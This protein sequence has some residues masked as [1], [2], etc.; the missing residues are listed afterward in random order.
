VSNIDGNFAIALDRKTEAFRRRFLLVI[1]GG[2]SAIGFIA[3][4][5]YIV[6][7][8]QPATLVTVAAFLAATCG[9][10]VLTSISRQQEAAWTLLFGIAGAA[11][12]GLAWSA[13][14]P[15]AN[16]AMMAMMIAV[17]MAPFLVSQRGVVA[18]TA[19]EV[20]LIALGHGKMA[21][22]DGLP[23]DQLA[24]PAVGTSLVVIA[25]AALISTFVR[26]AAQNQAMLRQRLVDID[27][28]VARA[29]RIA[30]GD[31]SGSVA[32]ETEMSQVIASMLSG[33][34]GL[35]EQIQENAA[36]VGSASSEIAAMAQQQEL[37]AVE[38]GSAIE[39][40]RRTLA[41]MVEAST[42]I[43]DSARGVSENAQATLENAQRITARIHTL[44][45]HTQRITEILEIIKDVANKSELLALNAALEG[46]KAG[47]AGRGFSLVASQMQRLAESV[48]ESVK[49]VKELTAN[50]REAT[51]ATAL[52]TEDATRLAGETAEA[53]RRI[54]AITEH[55]STSTQQVTHAVDDIAEAT[56]QG[57]AGTN[58]TLQAVRE[59]SAIAE[60]LNEYVG[61]FQ[62]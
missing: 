28:I 14:G 49:G 50:I 39:E 54:H 13:G 44:A 8:P 21:L 10:L 1:C 17:V 18:L 59:L 27:A 46:T 32:G 42:Q 58:Q 52:A 26:H 62:L 45:G 25:M 51:N 53:A 40:T 61:R 20:V 47:E 16:G 23:G 3:C 19:T 7:M 2:L 36:R 48:M 15:L 33:L 60:R 5:V 57:A 34:R 41:A 29:Q 22:V 43:A 35:V 38:Q 9:G 4:A 11:G 6:V 31:L 37:S 12:I 56:H 55:Q 24:S 30:T